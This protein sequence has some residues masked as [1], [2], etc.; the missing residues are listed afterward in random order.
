MVYLWIILKQILPRHE[1]KRMRHGLESSTHRY[2]Y[3]RTHIHT[4]IHTV[5]H[6]SLKKGPMVGPTDDGPILGVPDMSS[7]PQRYN[8]PPRVPQHHHDNVGH[9]TSSRVV[10]AEKSAPRAGT[11]ESHQSCC[12][13][14]DTLSTQK[15]QLKGKDP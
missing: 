8:C 15:K 7:Q 12:H 4:H 9:G 14:A 5:R 2:I 10:I 11:G 13:C 3:I 1:H 6:L